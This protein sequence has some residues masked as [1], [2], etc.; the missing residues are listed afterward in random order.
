MVWTEEEALALVR[1]SFPDGSA[2]VADGDDRH[3]SGVVMNRDG[4]TIASFRFVYPKPFRGDRE[5][6]VV[7]VRLGQPGQFC[8]TIDEIAEFERRFPAVPSAE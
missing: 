4:E 8:G 3:A 1:H 2:C 6:D 7:E 5:A